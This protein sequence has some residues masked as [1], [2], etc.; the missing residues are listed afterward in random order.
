MRTERTELQLPFSATRAIGLAIAIG[1]AVGLAVFYF[2][3]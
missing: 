3:R 2:M 1:I